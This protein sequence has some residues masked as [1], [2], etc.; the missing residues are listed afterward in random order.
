MQTKPRGLPKTGGR[1][2]G[3]INKDS[4]PARAK[5]KELGIDP[6]EILL[7]FA[8]G[9]WEKLGYKAESYVVEGNNHI[10][11]KLF[12]EPGIRARAAAEACQ[13]IM[14]KLKA[15][16]HSG[17][18]DSEITGPQVV[19]TLPDNGRTGTDSGA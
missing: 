14:P 13:Y 1:K 10:N 3:S 6:F 17:S 8:A 15:I 7:Y 2:K 19:I 16:E 11:E 9:N 4:V 18:I 12:I 5:A